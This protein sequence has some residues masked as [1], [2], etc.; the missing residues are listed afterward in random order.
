MLTVDEFFRRMFGSLRQSP[1]NGIGHSID[2][3]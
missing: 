3:G 2:V 1:P